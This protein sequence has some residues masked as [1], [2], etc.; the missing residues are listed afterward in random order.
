MA[1][2]GLVILAFVIFHLLHFTTGSIQS[3]VDAA[4]QR[5]DFL[6][7]HDSRGR[8]DVYAMMI[9]GFREPWIV[10]AYVIAQILLGVHLSHGIASMFQTLG[11]NRPSIWPLIRG[12]GITLAAILMIGN[13]V[14]PLAVYFRMVG[15]EYIR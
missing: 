7:L 6:S 11:S 10:I 2:T 8:H 14:M 12:A 13:I 15:A 1:L 4:G 3:G 5:H 9:N